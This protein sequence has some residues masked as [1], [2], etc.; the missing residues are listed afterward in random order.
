MPPPP[1]APF[2]AQK[3]TRTMTDYKLGEYFRKNVTLPSD[4][5][6]LYLD[7][8]TAWEYGKLQDQVSAIQLE[9]GLMLNNINV[10]RGDNKIVRGIADDDPTA[11]YQER[12]D[13][14]E[15]ELG[16]LEVSIKGVLEKLSESGVTFHLRAMYPKEI[17]MSEEAA[18]RAIND[19]AKAEKTTYTDEEKLAKTN[20]YAYWL[21]LEKSVQKVVYPD[22]H[23]E[24]DFTAKDFEDFKGVVDDGEY[25]RLIGLLNDLNTKAAIAKAQ[26]DAG[27]PGRRTEQ[28]GEQ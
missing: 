8:E 13:E 14:I 21:Y 23:E 25:T 16:G 4:S 11:K 17:S 9:Q 15:A 6:T 27:F 19:R 2:K 26:D 22:G 7:G 1:A 20:E 24:T 5:V 12:L 18:A 10:A 28:T 3:G